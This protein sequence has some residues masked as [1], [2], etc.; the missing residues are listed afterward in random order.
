MSDDKIIKSAMET[1]EKTLDNAI[2]KHNKVTVIRLDARYD[3][4]SK[5]EN[6]N[7]DI[8]KLSKNIKQ[9]L[10]NRRV[11]S[12]TVWAREQKTSENPHYHMAVLVDGN[13]IQSPHDVAVMASKSWKH[14]TGSDK[15]GLIHRGACITIRRPSS[16]AEGTVRKE[17]ECQ[18]QQQRQQ[19][20]DALSYLAKTATKDQTPPHAK[21]F[22]ASLPRRQNKAQ[23]DE[24]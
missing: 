24:N 23:D 1:I 4:T 22:H 12:N 3:T 14:I 7:Q 21:R 5:P 17:Q 11:N 13:K 2:E 19:A 8:S 20:L 16:K 18:F 6:N 9:N 15:D 10:N